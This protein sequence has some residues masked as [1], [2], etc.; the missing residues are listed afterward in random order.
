MEAETVADAALAEGLNG[1]TMLKPPRRAHLAKVA[2]AMAEDESRHTAYTE[3][4]V[5]EHRSSS[6]LRGS[7]DAVSACNA[8]KERASELSRRATRCGLG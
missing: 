6:Q 7:G 3:N 4:K 8:R 1:S 5:A 2:R